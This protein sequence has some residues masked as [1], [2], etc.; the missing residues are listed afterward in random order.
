M[1]LLI[2]FT[3]GLIRN[4]LSDTILGYEDVPPPQEEQGRLIALA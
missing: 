2:L 3:Q 4:P 1:L